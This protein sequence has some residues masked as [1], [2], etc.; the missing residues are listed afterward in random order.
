[1]PQ[2]T[3]RI[4]SLTVALATAV[5]TTALAVRSADAGPKRAMSCSNTACHL[6]LHCDWVPGYGCAFTQKGD[7]ITSQCEPQ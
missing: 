6:T 4:L 5:G 7:C 2:S 1:M 3:R